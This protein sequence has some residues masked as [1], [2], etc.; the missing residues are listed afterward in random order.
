MD[1]EISINSE[2]IINYLSD[3]IE[4]IERTLSEDEDFCNEEI[5]ATYQAA[6]KFFEHLQIR[7][8]EKLTELEQKLD[9]SREEN[10]QL[11]EKNK[12]QFDEEIDEINQLFS[13]GKHQEGLKDFFLC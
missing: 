2:E 1:V 13:S 6:K 4:C 7:F 9:H 11:S 12:K 5:D 8:N 3:R 10:V